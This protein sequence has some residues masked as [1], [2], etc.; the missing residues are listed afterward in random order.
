MVFDLDVLDSYVVATYPDLRK[1]INSLQM[2]CVDGEL[3]NPTSDSNAADDYKIKAV[4]MF[5][6]G[7]VRE[8]RKLMC[9]QIRSDEVDELFRWMYDNLDLWGSSDEEQDKAI[10]IIRNGLVNH[11]MVAD[12]EI[13]LAATLIELTDITN[14]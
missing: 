1:C 8:A 14:G 2:A 11:S 10:I 7:R 3:K 6:T 12:V 9:S 13:N 4:E 5:K